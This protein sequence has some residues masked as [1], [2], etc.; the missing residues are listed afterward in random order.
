[1]ESINQNAVQKTPV[2][3]NSTIAARTETS[4]F[5]MENVMRFGPALFIATTAAL[6]TAAAP[7]LARNSETP[8]ASEQPASSSCRSYQQAA[9]KSW[10]ELPCQEIGATPSRKSSARKTDH[11]V[12]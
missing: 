11:E 8:K 4:P 1:L 3:K 6:L 9:D 7:G 10:V 12:R 5:E 2:Q